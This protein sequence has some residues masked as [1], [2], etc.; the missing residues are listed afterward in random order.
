[1]KG[2]NDTA[3]GAPTRLIHTLWSRSYPHQGTC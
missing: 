1:V 2:P 3:K